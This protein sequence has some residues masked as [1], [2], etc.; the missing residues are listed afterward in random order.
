MAAGGAGGRRPG[1]I[2]VT[3]R[4]ARATRRAGAPGQPHYGD[5]GKRAAELLPGRIRAAGGRA[6]TRSGPIGVSRPAS[7]GAPICPAQ[8]RP[9][10]KSPPDRRG[11]QNAS[12]WDPARLRHY[13]RAEPGGPTGAGNA[14]EHRVGDEHRRGDRGDRHRC[15]GRVELVLDKARVPGARRPRNPQLRPLHRHLHPFLRPRARCWW[16][17][18]RIT[19]RTAGRQGNLEPAVRR[20]GGKVAWPPP[21]ELPGIC[22]HPATLVFDD[23]SNRWYGHGPLDTEKCNNKDVEEWHWIYLREQQNGNL[24]GEWIEDSIQCYTKRTLTFTRTGDADIS[25]LPDPA[26][27]PP[28]VASQALFLH[29]IYRSKV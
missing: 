17:K 26:A 8:R 7:G 22:P 1:R 9:P 11:H 2:R 24:A 3:D 19:G 28:R 23:V 21:R 15:G 25:S 14:A 18:D 5:P 20:A 10:T 27:L 4:G 13:S 6:Y 16:G 29:G 12:R